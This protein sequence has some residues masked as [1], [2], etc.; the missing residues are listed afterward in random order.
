[1]NVANCEMKQTENGS[2]Q[3]HLKLALEHS[4]QTGMSRDS[5]QSRIEDV[6]V[7]EELTHLTRSDIL[8]QS[9]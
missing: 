3:G 5:A 7:A 8:M 1:M 4:R 2:Q 9:G 6:D